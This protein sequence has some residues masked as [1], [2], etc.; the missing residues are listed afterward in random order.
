MRALGS[1]FLSLSIRLTCSILLKLLTGRPRSCTCVIVTASIYPKGANCHGKERECTLNG[2]VSL[3]SVNI[4]SNSALAS[5]CTVAVV[6][7]VEGRVYEQNDWQLL[8]LSDLP[9]DGDGAAPRSSHALKT[10]LPWLFPAA[11]F[12]VFIDNKL[13]AAGGRVPLRTVAMM[14]AEVRFKQC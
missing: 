8:R 10:L 7:E 5:C 9:F 1:E 14:L 3:G 11:L 2:T 6:S 12:S 4:S 13:R